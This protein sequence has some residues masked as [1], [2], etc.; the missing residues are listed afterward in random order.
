[1]TTRLSPMLQS[2]SEFLASSFDNFTQ[3]YFAN[4][5]DLWSHDPIN[6][7]LP[8]QKWTLRSLQQYL[9]NQI[10]FSNQGYLM[11]D[12]TVLG[13]N[14]NKPPECNGVNAK[15]KELNSITSQPCCW[16]GPASIRQPY[17]LRQPSMPSNRPYWMPTSANNS[18]I[19]LSQY[20]RVSP[21]Q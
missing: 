17:W 4:H 1:M 16:L 5:S 9:C 15:N 10:Q 13:V 7:Q 21:I 11:F 6:R 2:Y 20:F 19:Q 14:G 18:G 3:T 12:D 8:S